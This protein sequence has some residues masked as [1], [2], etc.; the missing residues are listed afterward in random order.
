LIGEKKMFLVNNHGKAPQSWA[1]E[2][3]AGPFGA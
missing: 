2:E 3:K 1:P